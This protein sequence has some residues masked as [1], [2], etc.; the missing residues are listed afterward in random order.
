MADPRRTTACGREGAKVGHEQAVSVFAG[1]V[2][3][4]RLVG[5]SC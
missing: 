1:L 5:V 2:L 3:I 4:P